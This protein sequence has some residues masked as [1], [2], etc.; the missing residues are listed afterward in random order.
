MRLYYCFKAA[1]KFDSFLKWFEKL[2]R[3]KILPRALYFFDL[4]KPV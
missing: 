4:S 1:H 2:V 3:D